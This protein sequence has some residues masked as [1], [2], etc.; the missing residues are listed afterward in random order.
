MLDLPQRARLVRIRIISCLF[1]HLFY[2]L[3]DNLRYTFTP[4]A[5]TTPS[6]PQHV[7]TIIKAAAANGFQ[8]S[9]RGGGVSL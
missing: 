6:T 8:V 7:S 5:V 1:T 3:A 4:A 9:A 2:I